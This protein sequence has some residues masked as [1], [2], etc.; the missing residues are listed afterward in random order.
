M[1]ETRR[2]LWDDTKIS[3]DQL[4]KVQNAINGDDTKWSFWLDWFDRAL[5]GTEF[6][7][8]LLERIALSD[9]PKDGTEPP[10][11]SYHA[12]WKGTDAEVNERINAIWE[13]WIGE[14]KTQNNL[15]DAD[16]EGAV[17]ATPN[18]EDVSLDTETQK[19][20]TDPITDVTP[21][22][23]ED[24][25]A[26]I[27]E[28]LSRVLGD[29]DGMINRLPLDKELSMLSDAR[30]HIDAPAR[31][32]K[33]CRRALGRV[34][35]KI[36]NGDCPAQDKDPDMED[37]VGTLLEVTTTLIN[38]DPE[39]KEAFELMQEAPTLPADG[40]DAAAMSEASENLVDLS[41]GAM[42]EDFALYS[43][44]IISMQVTQEERREAFYVLASRMAR[45][46][47]AMRKGLAD[48]N[49][50]FKIYK[51]AAT[52]VGIAAGA[53]T[54]PLWWKNAMEIIL[55]FFG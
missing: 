19:W 49:A 45:M 20:R 53:A 21:N 29:V 54:S 27:E 44:I 16:L 47:S 37:L 4:R 18:A 39:V 5:A 7:W 41:E 48:S 55:K 1:P 24:A 3:A 50:V 23:M 43:Q 31:L 33:L 46:E 30:K 22:H 10:A 52:N 11:A 32:H 12:F 40:E 42:S 15:Q 34:R 26:E 36:N 38:R 2:P 13:H 9:V 14:P 25:V 28:M 6:R 17:V 8:D 35:A 51:D